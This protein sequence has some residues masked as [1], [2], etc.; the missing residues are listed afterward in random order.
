MP[1]LVQDADRKINLLKEVEDRISSDLDNRAKELKNRAQSA[2][3]SSALVTLVATIAALLT[4]YFIT[5]SITGPVAMLNG[6]MG[7]LAS[8]KVT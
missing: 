5:R 8:G 7:E 4:A 6:S 2:L 3:T 1:L